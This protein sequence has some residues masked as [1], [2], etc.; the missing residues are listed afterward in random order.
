MTRGFEK[1]HMPRGLRPQD[2]P[3]GAVRNEQSGIVLVCV[4]GAVGARLLDATTGRPLA[5][6]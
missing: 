6:I 1:Y 5:N 2:A 3:N 4:K